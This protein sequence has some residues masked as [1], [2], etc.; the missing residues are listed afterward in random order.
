VTTSPAGVLAVADRSGPKIA[1][2]R[3]VIGRELSEA[4]RRSVVLHH[5]LD[6]PGRVIGVDRLTP[7]P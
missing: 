4:Q 6:G 3:V 5:G 2:V 7:R 1:V